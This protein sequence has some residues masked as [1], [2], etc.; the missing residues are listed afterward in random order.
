MKPTPP[1]TPPPP[2]VEVVEISL[3][4]E[5]CPFMGSETSAVGQNPFSGKIQLAK[6]YGQC[7]LGRCMLWHEPSKKCLARVGL[8]KLAGL[9]P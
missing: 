9:E 6:Q 5:I 7:V 1:A 3:G 8:A 4:P 2:Q